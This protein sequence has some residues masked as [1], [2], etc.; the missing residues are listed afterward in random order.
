MKHNC[1]DNNPRCLPVFYDV[2]ETIYAR[3]TSCAQAFLVT[4]G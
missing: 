1:T 2:F 3:H 4:D